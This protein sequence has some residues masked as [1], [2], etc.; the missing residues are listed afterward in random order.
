M[1]NIQ[2]KINKITKALK[3]KGIMPLINSE[4]FYIDGNQVTKHIIHY[5]QPRGKNND[6]V[7]EVYSKKQLLDMLV[8][9]L[10]EGGN[11]G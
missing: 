1:I 8:K 2:R 6:V 10:K 9:I 7:A 4:Q 11:S 5:G 3:A